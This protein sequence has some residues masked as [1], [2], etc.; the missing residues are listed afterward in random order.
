MKPA[1]VEL[2]LEARR[3]LWRGGGV[4]PKSHMDEQIFDEAVTKEDFQK[5]LKPETR[6]R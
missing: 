3:L 6:K 4:K 1:M 2:D 5:G